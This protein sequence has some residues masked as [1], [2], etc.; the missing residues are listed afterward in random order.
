M[1]YQWKKKPLLIKSKHNACSALMFDTRSKREREWCKKAVYVLYAAQ[2][3]K[4]PIPQQNTFNYTVF[5]CN[6]YNLLCTGWDRILVQYCTTVWPIH[7]VPYFTVQRITD[8]R[9]WRVHFRT[10]L[11]ETRVR[12]GVK[13]V[14]KDGYSTFFWQSWEEERGK[15]SGSKSFREDLQPRAK[16]ANGHRSVEGWNCWP[17]KGISARDDLSSGW[18]QK[19]EQIC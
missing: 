14:D 12:V 2:P 19:K 7:T 17:N 9:T 8:Y 18:T 6:Q 15:K 1:L 13:F 11:V 5:Y 3:G 10:L 4:Q 16:A